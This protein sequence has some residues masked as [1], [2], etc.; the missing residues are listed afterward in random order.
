MRVCGVG[1][2][3]TKHEGRK[4]TVSAEGKESP[5]NQAPLSSDHLST[6]A[7]RVLSVREVVL[8]AVAVFAV[9]S[10]WVVQCTRE[11]TAHPDAEA[12]RQAAFRM[13]QCVEKIASHRRAQTKSEEYRATPLEALLGVEYSSITTTLGS[14]QAKRTTANPNFA[15]LVVRLLRQAGVDSGDVV[16]MGFSGSF[17]GLCI[18]AITGAEALRARPVVISSVGASSWGANLPWLTWLDMEQV[19][20]EHGLIR[21]RSV[22]ATVGAEADTGGGLAEEGRRLA[23]QAA[24]RTGVPLLEVRGVQESISTRMHI[25][26]SAGRVK[27]FLNVGGNQADLGPYFCRR[28]LRPGLILH[29]RRVAP[30]EECGV[31]QR[32]LEQGVPVVHLLDVRQL[33]ARYGLPFDPLRMPEVGEGP[34]YQLVRYRPAVV[35]CCLLLVVAGAFCASL[36]RRCSGKAWS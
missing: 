20:W 11:V 22:A 8:S 3:G 18:A 23:W 26:R 1:Q 25:Y 21:T 7:A 35:A 16:A 10:L 36:V 33:C 32:F 2:W 12:M 6:I 27:T 19:L 15:A 13:K 29:P 9:A 34:V 28:L 24:A 14:L 17:P 30:G 31:S 4:K 5:S